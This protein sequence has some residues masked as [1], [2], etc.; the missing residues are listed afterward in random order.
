[1]EQPARVYRGL[2]GGTGAER[3]KGLASG[4][5]KD[6]SPP[7]VSCLQAV[8]LSAFR[9][10][11]LIHSD[12]TSVVSCLCVEGFFKTHGLLCALSVTESELN[13]YLG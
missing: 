9:R 13:L 1:M 2:C 10:L 3:V 6:W 5:V 7:A 11:R 8:L 12:W 4:Q